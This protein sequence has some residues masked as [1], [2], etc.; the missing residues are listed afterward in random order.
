VL[1]LVPPTQQERFGTNESDPFNPISTPDGTFGAYDVGIGLTYAQELGSLWTAGGTVQLIRESIDNENAQT[2]AVNL[3]VLRKTALPGLTLGASLLNFGPG[4]SFVTTYPLPLTGR[5]GAAYRPF[6]LSSAP[7][8]L[9]FTFDVEQPNDDYMW[10]SGGAEFTPIPAFTVRAGYRERL[11]GDPLGGLSGLRIG[12]GIKVA[13]V[14]VDYAFAP[15]GDLGS[16][17]RISITIPW[18]KAP[19]PPPKAKPAET[20]AAPAPL[21]SL[22]SAGAPAIALP[23]ASAPSAELAAAMESSGAAAGFSIQSRA[24]AITPQGTVYE[25]RASNAL[26]SA[27]VQGVS[28]KAVLPPQEQVTFDAVESAQSGGFDVLP[29]T[30]AFYRLLELRQSPRVPL[31][32]ITLRLSVDSA[33]LKSMGAG[34]DR[35][36]LFRVQDGQAVPQLTVFKEDTS[37]SDIYEAMP[38]VLGQWF[39]VG[40][41]KPQP[42]KP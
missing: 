19:S 15:A 4:N 31:R 12:A 26:S 18:G 40:V 37:G 34:T 1:T 23:A 14:H 39:I 33:W 17:N 30:Y 38:D 41:E 22:P 24:M 10:F 16:Q 20:A 5:I 21:P 32:A 27:T 25:V 2:F 9:M 8:K 36:Q 13:D 11:Y 3:G 35:V 28:F 42:A 6:V 29:S 7:D